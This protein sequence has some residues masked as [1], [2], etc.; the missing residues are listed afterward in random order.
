M[1][2]INILVVSIIILLAMNACGLK[3]EEETS[4][5]LDSAAAMSV[6][7]PPSQFDAIKITTGKIEQKQMHAVLEVNGMLDVPPQNLVTVSALM[8]GF[9]KS[10]DI[11]QGM[12]V[13][14]GA[15]IATIQNPEF[16]TI[17]KDY[18]ENKS[19]L[20]YLEL[21]YKRQEEL[22]KENVTS[23]KTFQQISSEY[24]SALVINGALTEKL[25]MIG[26]NPAN[27]SQ[28][29]I[30][31]VVDLRSPINGYIT[32]VNI[33]IGSFVNPQDIICEIVDTDHLHAELT[34]FEKDITK[35]KVGQK[36]VF[37]I[38]NGDAKERTAKVYLINHKIASDRTVR[39]HA[40]M[41]KN[42]PALIPN[43][44]LKAYI[45]I[46]E[47][48]VLAVPQKA[49]VQ[50]EDED[51]IF[52]E[53][54]AGNKHQYE[55]IKVQKGIS[56]NGYTEIILPASLDYNQINVVIDGAYDLLSKLKNIEEEE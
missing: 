46:D 39:V 38:V 31:S 32:V 9:I 3:K 36:I 17:Q 37:K 43:M 15:L 51:Y 26:I 21:E 2:A 52:I 27:V 10:T 18:L 44:Y 33:N 4:E 14:K 28:N 56:E 53:K 25:K 41:D 55:G 8:G 1:K 23:A 24:N 45:Y 30:T 20:K 7:L 49:V 34:V 29:T 13:K 6:T 19:R 11:L 50:I 54:N 35:V 12:N 16:V 47:Q 22:A 42:D 40:H 48:N 5:T